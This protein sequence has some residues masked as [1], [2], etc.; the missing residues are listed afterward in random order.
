M[1][2]GGGKTTSETKADPWEGVR[3]YLLDLFS[4]GKQASNQPNQYYPGQTFA[5]QDPLSSEYYARMS[6]IARNGTPES[7]QVGDY[8]G[9]VLSGKYTGQENPYLN[10]MIGNMT[11][12]IGADV[13]DRFAAS[14]G[15]MGSPGEQQMVSGEVSKAAMPYLF[16]NYGQE[17]GL[18]D[19][20]AR[21]LELVD[22]MNRSSLG[23]LLQAGQANQQQSQS[24]I[25]EAIQRWNY[26]RDSNWDTLNKYSS[27][28]QPG[29]SF[30][31]QSGQ[32]SGPGTD[33]GQ[34]AGGSIGTLGTLALMAMMFS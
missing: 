11:N 6:D 33:W 27:I 8:Y 15:Y 29:T 18:Q 12:T 16:Q 9:D 1:S 2:G 23:G 3:P 24:A 30:S 5:N 17:R 4:R 25:D 28:L 19:S 20:A 14:G 22:Q 7:N 26:N 32:Q 31:T 21:N 34:V 13:G 10:A